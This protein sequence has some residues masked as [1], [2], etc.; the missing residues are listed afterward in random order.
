MTLEARKSTPKGGLPRAG[1]Q[2]HPQGRQ[3]DRGYCCDPPD[4]GGWVK[5]Q[6][7]TLQVTKENK[8]KIP[9]T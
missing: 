4:M 1:G 6:N 9:Q 3:G 8:N 5:I 2:P 7:V